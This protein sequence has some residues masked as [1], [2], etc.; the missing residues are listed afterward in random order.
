MHHIKMTKK[1]WKSEEMGLS[2]TTTH[3][4]SNLDVE[5]AAL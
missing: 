5:R 3:L 1:A 4:A 2:K